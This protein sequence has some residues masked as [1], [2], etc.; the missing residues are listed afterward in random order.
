MGVECR[1]DGWLVGS[2]SSDLIAQMTGWQ[3][4]RLE[5]SREAL[6][7][8]YPRRDGSAEI[9]IPWADAKDVS[10]AASEAFGDCVV[11]AIRN[12]PLSTR[13]ETALNVSFV[14]RVLYGAPWTLG[15]S[16]GSLS[17][18]S[19]APPAEDVRSL[20]LEWGEESRGS[21]T[22]V[23]TTPKE[24][25]SNR[26]PAEVPVDRQNEVENVPTS[27]PSEQID[28]C[29]ATSEDLLSLPGVGP[30]EAELIVHHRSL[31]GGIE[32]LEHLAELLKLKPHVVERLRGRLRFALSDSKSECA[33]TLGPVEDATDKPRPVAGEGSRD[34]RRI[35]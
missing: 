6:L 33:E 16:G 26:A 17:I 1:G 28:I 24:L 30:A 31:P 19:I 11:I 29:T 35:D 8:S 10:V 18:Y 4:A 20:I 3:E 2:V 32:S 25:E 13:I 9:V 12:V 34:V 21:P 15:D 23:E 27:D 22:A 7:V 14:S 5:R